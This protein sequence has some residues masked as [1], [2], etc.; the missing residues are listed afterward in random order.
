MTSSTQPGCPRTE[1]LAALIDGELTPGAQ[2]QIATHAAA[3][4]LCGA[5]LKDLTDLHVALQPFAAA[6]VGFD[7]APLVERRL[8][9]SGR[10]QQQWGRE[11]RW[12]QGREL[13]SSGLAAAG[14]L[15]VGVYLGALLAGGTAV[16][17]ARPAA[18]AVFDSI[19]PGGICVG[20][21]S[22]YA[23]R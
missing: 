23:Q 2:Q 4:P 8:A 12:W 14:M 5:M 15:T 9:A 16:A 3:C 1:Q 11:P 21:R 6:R 22:C 17:V 7:V 18:L 10:R 20:L 19:P 13:L